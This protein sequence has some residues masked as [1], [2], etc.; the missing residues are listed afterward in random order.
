MYL[1]TVSDDD[2]SPQSLTSVLYPG[3]TMKLSSLDVRPYKAQRIRR[4]VPVEKTQTKEFLPPRCR[5]LFS[6]VSLLSKCRF[7]GYYQNSK[8]LVNS[9]ELILNVSTEFSDKIFIITV[10]G[11]ELGT[12]CV[13]DQDATTAP[14]RH[15]WEA[16]SLN[17][18][19][20][21]LQWFIRFSEFTEFNESSVPFR[22]NSS[23]IHFFVSSTNFYTKV[24]CFWV[25]TTYECPLNYMLL[26]LNCLHRDEVPGSTP[27]SSIPSP[28]LRQNK[29]SLFEGLPFSLNFLLISR[30]TYCWR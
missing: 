9:V 16:G 23:E 11:L 17:W 5:C 29:H 15:L 1:T 19:Q 18:A 3:Q 30:I 22:K 24:N 14:A 10:K 7:F 8:N 2:T 20:F 28:G 6:V 4:R 27:H 13:R 12:S 25:N 26:S 21:M